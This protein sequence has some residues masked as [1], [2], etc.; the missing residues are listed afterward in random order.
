MIGKSRITQKQA[1]TEK[2]RTQRGQINVKEE[3]RLWK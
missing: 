2:A 3:L 1:T